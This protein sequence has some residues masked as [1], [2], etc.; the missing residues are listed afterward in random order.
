MWSPRCS[1]RARPQ[2]AAVV[3]QSLNKQHAQYP[4]RHLSAGALIGFATPSPLVIFAA[5]VA[6]HEG[7]RAH[8]SEPP[9]RHRLGGALLMVLYLVFVAVVV[10][11]Q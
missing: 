9:P 1:S 8:R 10:R 3:S 7:R 6:G 11:W 5:V 2:H 4:R